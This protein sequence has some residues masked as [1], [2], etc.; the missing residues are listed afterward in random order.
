MLSLQIGSSA[1]QRSIVLEPHSGLTA[2]TG[3]SSLRVPLPNNATAAMW[4]VIP[5]GSGFL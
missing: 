4:S 3:P 2:D 5:N 1:V